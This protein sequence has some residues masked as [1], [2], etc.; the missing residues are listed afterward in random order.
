[1]NERTGD[2]LRGAAL[3]RARGL[4]SAWRAWLLP[5]RPAADRRRDVTLALLSELMGGAQP[6]RPAE[7]VGKRAS[8]AMPGGRREG[9]AA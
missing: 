4:L 1:M 6:R 7:L 9:A 8:D 3:R 5:R 2:V